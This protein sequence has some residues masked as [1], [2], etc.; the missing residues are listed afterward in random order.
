MIRYQ[1]TR[2]ELIEAI[3]IEKPTWSSRASR[4]TAKFIRDKR[5]DENSSIWS[6]VKPVYIA[7]QRNKCVF[8]ERKFETREYGKIEY[9]LEHFRPKS[10]VKVWP[11]ASSEFNYDFPTGSAS[12]KGYYWLAYDS[13]NYAASCKVCNSTLKSNYFPI[14]RNRGRATSAPEQLRSEEPYLCYPISNFDENPEKLVTFTATVA[15]PVA[16]R[17]WKKK[18]G[19]VIIDFFRL[20]AR[21][22]LHQE[23]AQMIMLLGNALKELDAGDEIAL[24]MQIINKATGNAVPHSACSRAFR[25][26][27]AE[28]EP[29]ARRIHTRCREYFAGIIGID[30]IIV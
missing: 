25:S 19:Q 7:L 22:I 24:N 26:L 16:R 5:F 2:Q 21:Q 18:R 9:D 3:R 14:A 11:N 10:S 8:C 20:N 29:L 6:E 17:G 4:R 23:R 1:T 15:R 12:S 28:E 27:W 13:L 30:D